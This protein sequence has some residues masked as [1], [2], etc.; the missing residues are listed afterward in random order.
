M[1]EGQTGMAGAIE[2]WA[3]QGQRGRRERETAEAGS[4]GSGTEVLRRLA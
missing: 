4:G 1:K 3:W 2:L